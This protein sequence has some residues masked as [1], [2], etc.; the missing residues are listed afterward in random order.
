MIGIDG[1][2][3]AQQQTVEEK[4][5]YCCVSVAD[6]TN[7]NNNNNNNTINSN[8]AGLNKINR[9]VYLYSVFKHSF[10]DIKMKNATNYEIKQIIE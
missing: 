6:S 10:P 3:T 9:L 4:F 8:S 5:N 2:I 7:N 1:K